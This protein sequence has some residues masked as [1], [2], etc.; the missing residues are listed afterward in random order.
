VFVFVILRVV[1]LVIFFVSSLLSTRGFIFLCL[2]PVGYHL[3]CLEK[4]SLNFFSWYHWFSLSL[5]YDLYHAGNGFFLCPTW[6]LCTSEV[7]C[8]WFFTAI[9]FILLQQTIK[10][11]HWI[12][13]TRLLLLY[14]TE[15]RPLFH[16]ITYS[17]HDEFLMS[18]RARLIVLLGPPWMS[19]LL[20]CCRSTAY[21]APHWVGQ[22]PLPRPLTYNDPISLRV[23]ALSH[24][25]AC[26]TFFSI[27]RAEVF[28]TWSLLLFNSF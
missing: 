11:R 1:V 9:W 24:S 10:V 6:L 13:F 27:L 16:N 17:V 26:Y 18:Q 19:C 22:V 3:S 14:T 7:E 4:I 15:Q 28:F 2:R 5:F 12:T 8:K 21:L 25:P 23:H 20:R